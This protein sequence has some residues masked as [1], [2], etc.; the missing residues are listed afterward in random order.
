MKNQISEVDETTVKILFEISHDE[1]KPIVDGV[2]SKITPNVSVSGF[3]KGKIPRQI[4]NAKVG[5]DH[6]VEEV[7]NAAISKFYLE[8][9][10]KNDLKIVSQADIKVLEEYNPATSNGA[11]NSFKFEAV[12]EIRLKIE[13]VPVDDH[14]LHIEVKDVEDKEIDEALNRIVTALE[15]AESDSKDALTS[16]QFN[17]DF[18]KD[19]GYDDVEDLKSNVRIQLEEKAKV[20]AIRS[21]FNEFLHE[22]VGKLNLKIPQKLLS[23]ELNSQI[24][25]EEE[26]TGKPVEKQVRDKLQEKLE[27]DIATRLYTDEYA[28]SNSIT[29]SNQEIVED[30]GALAQEFQ[31][32]AEQFVYENFSNPNVVGIVR[33]GIV[34][35]KVSESMLKKMR[36]VDQNGNEL[37]LPFDKNAKKE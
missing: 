12:V 33:S 5:T 32:P 37:K 24:K 28:D 3:R 21:A 29:A 16:G 1:M 10:S 18:A 6:I 27:M 36:V 26:K 2:Y 19:L 9:A 11:E 20:D 8:Y 25:Q 15:S 31:V 17:D 35:R 4:V 14:E 13:L 34:W 7:T 23:S 30:L 22:L